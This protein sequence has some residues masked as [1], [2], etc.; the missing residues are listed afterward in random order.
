MEITAF[1]AAKA[2]L[3]VLHTCFGD[4]DIVQ[5]GDLITKRSIVLVDKDSIQGHSDGE[6]AYNILNNLMFFCLAIETTPKRFKLLYTRDEQMEEVLRR[7][8]EIDKARKQ[9][10]ERLEHLN[11]LTTNLEEIK[12]AITQ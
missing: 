5:P 3:N 7:Q 12:N 6:K 8:I 2:T 1:N 10:T 11:V 4:N 9:I